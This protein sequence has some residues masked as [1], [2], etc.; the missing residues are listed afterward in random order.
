MTQRLPLLDKPTKERCT[1]TCCTNLQ[2]RQGDRFFEPQELAGMITSQPWDAPFLKALIPLHG[3]WEDGTAP[4][5]LC[6]HLQSNGDCSVYKD[7]PLLCREHGV[8]E[9]CPRDGCQYNGRY[10]RAALIDIVKHMMRIRRTTNVAPSEVRTWI[11]ATIQRVRRR[12]TQ[13]AEDPNS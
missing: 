10:D 4:L 6:H 8:M 1:G 5:Y 13:H 11:R 7:R 9:L 12:L 3:P 2:V